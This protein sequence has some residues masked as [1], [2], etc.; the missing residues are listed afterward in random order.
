M[1][2]TFRCKNCDRQRP[3]N[4][5]LKDPQQYCN[6]IDCQRAR[7]AAW[8]KL[9]RAI[10]SDYQKARQDDASRWREN[11]RASLY[12]RQYR[13]QH[14]DYVKSN[15]IKQRLRNQQRRAEARQK[16]I[17]KVDASTNNKCG[18]YIMTILPAKI[19][20]VDALLVEL[21]AY[22]GDSEALSINSS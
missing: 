9:K 10:D 6:L 5:R 16:K 13:Q 4:P 12:M 19:V 22:H 21:Q 17:V 15:T 18:T 2:K 3:A 14:P 20:K 1:A 11:K 7:K 8:I